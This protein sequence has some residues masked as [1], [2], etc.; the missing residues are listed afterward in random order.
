V[1][2]G[3]LGGGCQGRRRKEKKR[4]T[5]LPTSRSDLKNIFMVF[6]ILS[7]REAA[8]NAIKKYRRGKSTGFSLNFFGK[9][10][11]T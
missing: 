8:K 3:W 6:L 4:R 1:G 2:A 7:G 10:F 5:Y 11:S 9:K